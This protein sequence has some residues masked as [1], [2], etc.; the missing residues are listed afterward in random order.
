MN[1]K[2]TPANVGSMEGLGVTV[3]VLESGE[4]DQRT[5]DGVFSSLD[6]ACESIRRPYGA[7]YIVQWEDSAKQ[8]GSGRYTYTGHFTRVNG[9]CGDGPSTWQITPYVLDAVSDA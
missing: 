1:T 5:I 3:Y 4:Y 2:A 7:P 6:A 9:Y 8:S